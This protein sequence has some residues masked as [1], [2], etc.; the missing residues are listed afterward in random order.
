VESLRN[1]LRVLGPYPFVAPLVVAAGLVTFVVLLQARH[2]QHAFIATM[3]V[4]TLEGCLPLTAGIALAGVA[5]RDS[6]LEVLLTVQTAYRLTTAR[7][8]ALV[9]AWVLLL[10]VAATWIIRALFP[11]TILKPGVL[12]LLAW[13]APTLWLAGAALLLAYLLRSRSTSAAVLGCLWVAQLVFHGYFAA[14]GWTRP[15]FL[16]ATIYVPAAPFWVAN[17]LELVAIALV[18]FTA[19]W[20]FL[21]NAEWRLRAEDG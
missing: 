9:L 11:G 2:V 7:R 16:F 8:A 1:E 12:G 20:L 17:R 6:A 15:W 5:V 3:L 19:A 14:Y 13:A 18:C 21:R 10:E 4:V